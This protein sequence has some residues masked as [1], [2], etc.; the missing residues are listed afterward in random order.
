MRPTGP[1]P[2]SCPP[3]SVSCGG[4]LQGDP[5]G[6]VQQLPYGSLGSRSKTHATLHPNLNE[7]G[8]GQDR[9]SEVPVGEGRAGASSQV[10]PGWVLGATDTHLTGPPP[11][12]SPAAT[13]WESAHSPAHVRVKDFLQAA[14]QGPKAPLACRAAIPTA[15]CLSVAHRGWD[16]LWRRLGT[17]SR[18]TNKEPA[19]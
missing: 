15:D 19:C 11:L 3:T 13:S 6:H 16:L 2:S 14:A 8:Q 5:W 18:H 10:A 4:P 1:I 9:L 12:V 17:G 7:T